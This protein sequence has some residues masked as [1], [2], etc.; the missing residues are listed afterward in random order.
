MPGLPFSFLSVVLMAGIVVVH[1]KELKSNPIWASPQMKLFFGVVSIYG[2]IYFNAVNPEFHVDAA[3]NFFKLLVICALAVRLC[4]TESDFDT[5]TMGYVFAA[6]YLGLYI[7]Q[8]GRTAG[9]RV[10]GVGMP[11]APDANGIAA[12]MSPAVVLAV[13]HLWYADGWI[14]RGFLALAAAFIANALILINSRGSF[15]A[16]LASMVIYFGAT[17][18]SPRT[19]M[20]IKAYTL[21]SVIG[22]SGAI[23]YLADDSFIERFASISEGADQQDY[24]A[25]SGKTRTQFWLAAIEMSKDFPW[26]VGVYG[27][28]YYAPEYIDYSVDTGGV[29]NRS[30]HSTWFEALTEIGYL[31]LGLFLLMLFFSYRTCSKVQRLA[32]LDGNMQLYSR[33]LSIK[34]ALIAFVVAM[35]FMNRLRADLL[36]WMVMYSGCLYSIYLYKAEERNLTSEKNALSGV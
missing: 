27:F 4:V 23:L 20:K 15:L 34:G 8:M 22:F 30:V 13:H 12:A 3:I 21:A 25:E 9:D 14:K 26:G 18:V 35:T 32:V 2:L 16:V 5:M 10:Q 24:S 17:L 7:T 28:D 29:R 1:Y 31:G 19:P 11:D 33:A 6:S 36:Y